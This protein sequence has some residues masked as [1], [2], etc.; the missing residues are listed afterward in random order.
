MASGKAYLR[1][2]NSDLS[3]DFLQLSQPG[4]NI[5][6]GIDSTGAPYG[7]LANGNGGNKNSGFPQFGSYLFSVSGGITS[8]RN[9]ST[10]AIDYSDPDAAIVIRSAIAN[11]PNGGRLLFNDGVYNLNSLVQETTGGFSHYYAVGIP[12]GGPALYSS[13]VF[14]GESWTP[15]I[16]LFGGNGVQTNGVVFNITATA[17]ASAPANVVVMGIW[18]RPDITNGVGGTVSIKKLCVRMP[19]NQR[20]NTTGIDMSQA[21]QADLD[22][23]TTDYNIPWN[24]VVFPVAGSLGQYGIVTTASSKEENYLK[25]CLAFGSNVGLDLQS[26]HTILLNSYAANCN[27]AIDY[28]VRGGS[29]YHPSS[30]LSCGWGE[31]ARGLTLG[32]NC[33]AGSQLD[34]SGLDMEDGTLGIEP[35]PFLPVYHAQETNVGNTFGKIS[36]TRVKSNVGILPLATL[37]DG[38]GGTRIETQSSLG[39]TNVFLATPSIPGPAGSLSLGNTSALT[40]TIGINSALSFIQ[41]TQLP[42]TGAGGGQV[43]K[44]FVSPTTVGSYLLCWVEDTS[45]ASATLSVTDTLG[46][47][48]A[49][50]GS[51]VNLSG[52]TNALFQCVSNIGGACTVIIAATAGHFIISG[53]AEWTNQAVSSPLDAS[54]QAT[55]SS[56]TSFSSSNVT[57][58]SNNEQ[59]IF[60]GYASLGAVITAGA[61]YILRM[62]NGAGAVFLQDSNTIAETTG[63]YNA[64]LTGAPTGNLGGWLIS[65]KSAGLPVLPNNPQGYLTWNLNGVVVKIPFYNL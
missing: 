4:G 19:D 36:Y 5:V 27:H 32:A 60:L 8:A 21:I 63:T 50:I 1:W 46:N 57:T 43:T 41:A 33:L 24:N 59:L 53:I 10:G 26:E 37:F 22:S 52:T 23:V 42:P 38:G 13:W 12:S 58:G 49:Q 2:S 6:G 15:A 54:S 3:A 51:S 44:A 48:W 31:C 7:N 56:G 30:W 34:I 29:I 28:G 9:N 14:E 64:T 62:Q 18:Q 11:M 35:T 25:N 40:A 65:V 39:L 61:G 55:F 17:I 20:G 45:A 47:T 16:D